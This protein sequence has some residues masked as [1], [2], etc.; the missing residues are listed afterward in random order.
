M[1]NKEKLT[2]PLEI[3][4]VK[5]EGIITGYASVFNV[6][7]S[8]SD[9]IKPGAFLKS[10]TRKNNCKLLWQ[11]EYDQPVGVIK[12]IYEDD[13]GL[14]IEAKILLD[15]AKGRET[16]SLLKNGA[17]SGLSIGFT[18]KHFYV[19]YETDHRILT[20]IDLWEVSFVTFPSNPLAAVTCVK[21]D[22]ANEALLLKNLHR[23]IEILTN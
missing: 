13:Y 16:Y 15:V 11:H 17:M 20:E 21:A 19:D 4:S 1:N 5:K 6:V 2:F 22:G 18:P 9:V 12:R 23:A 10:L 7:D 8:H 3:K 14:F